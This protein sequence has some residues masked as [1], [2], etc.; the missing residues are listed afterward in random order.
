MA[1]DPIIHK[2]LLKP[3]TDHVSQKVKKNALFRSRCHFVILITA[4]ISSSQNL[5]QTTDVAIKLKPSEVCTTETHSK[6]C[7]GSVHGYSAAQ[8]TQV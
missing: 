1:T 5:Q 8:C 4:A 2:T 3:R 6:C 7:C